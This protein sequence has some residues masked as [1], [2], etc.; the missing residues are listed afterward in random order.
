MHPNKHSSLFVCFALGPG[1][2]GTVLGPGAG[3]TV[4]GSGPV[5]PAGGR[6]YNLTDCN[7]NRTLLC[8]IFC[9][10]ESQKCFLYDYPI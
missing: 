7:L 5:L 4:P 3:G 10:I 9:P 8:P 6:T 2:G 1:A